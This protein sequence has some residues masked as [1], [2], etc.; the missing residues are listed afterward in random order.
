MLNTRGY[1][2]D[3]KKLKGICEELKIKCFVFSTITFSEEKPVGEVEIKAYNLQD[4]NGV[5]KI[6]NEFYDEVKSELNDK[7][8]N[9][10]FY[11]FIDMSQFVNQAKFSEIPFFFDFGHT[12]FYTS[13]FIG[14]EM[15]RILNKELF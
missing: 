7:S 4:L 14:Q 1:I 3:Q 12:G 6:V 11:N 9:S 2:Y 8:I 15:G 13:K 10:S 5:N